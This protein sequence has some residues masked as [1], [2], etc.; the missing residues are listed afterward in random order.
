MGHGYGT[1]TIEAQVNGNQ[2]GPGIIFWPGDNTWPGQEID[3]MEITPNGSGAQ[4]GTLHWSQG[5]D[6]YEPQVFWGVSSG[7]PHEYQMIWEPGWLAM[8]IDGAVTASFADH[9][10]IDHALGG[11]NDTIGFLNNSSQTS[12]TVF[13][14]EYVPFG[15]STAAPTPVVISLAA[16]VDWTGLAAQMEANFLATGRWDVLGTAMPAAAQAE[17]VVDWNALAADV[18]AN[19]AATGYWHL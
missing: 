11:M 4:Y 9:V 14:V 7:V 2:P 16:A 5:G 15:T 19:F 17:T 8:K 10:P 12:L 18:E 13:S 3:L 6:A 1:Y